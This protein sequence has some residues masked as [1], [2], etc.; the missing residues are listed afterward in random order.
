MTLYHHFSLAKALP[1]SNS[2]SSLKLLR[3]RTS[4]KHKFCSPLYY[5]CFW[6]PDRNTY[7]TIVRIITFNTFLFWF[8]KSGCAQI[9]LYLGFYCCFDALKNSSSWTSQTA[10]AILLLTKPSCKKRG[11]RSEH[12]NR[13]L[14]FNTVCASFIA[15]PPSGYGGHPN[16]KIA[17]IALSSIFSLLQ[18]KKYRM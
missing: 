3:C 17:T 5:P 16:F 13:W 9:F 1:V 8:G 6:K 12:I 18:R 2:H 11:S 7:Q 15:H 10:Y 14:K 4:V